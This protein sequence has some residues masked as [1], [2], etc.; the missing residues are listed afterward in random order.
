MADELVSLKDV[1]KAILTGE[2]MDIIPPEQISADIVRR[3]LNADTIEEAF[4]SFDATPATEIEGLGVTV[5]GVTWMRS[6][7]NEGPPVYAL[8]RVTE[9]ATG[10]QSVVSMG[11]QTVMAGL[12]W[13]QKHD[14]LP[15]T[16][17]FRRK[18]SQSGDGNSYWTFRPSVMVAQA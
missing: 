4:G 11:G 3:V 5:H 16:G 9:D 2:G 8:M 17:V 14:A 7:F 13:A 6:S 1:E 15:I 10:V 18:Q 12:L